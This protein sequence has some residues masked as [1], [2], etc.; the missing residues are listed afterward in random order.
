MGDKSA[1]PAPDYTAA[2]HQQG[3]DS[4]NLANAQTAANRPNVTT[5]WGSITW[6]NNGTAANPFWSGDVKLTPAQQQALNSQQNI[7]QYQS[8]LAQSLLGKEAR[9]LTGDPNK[10]P[11]AQ[12]F[13]GAGKGINMDPS[14][15]DQKTTDAVWDQFKRMQMPLQQQ[16]TE[17]IQSQLEAQG[18][19]PG[20]A[21]YDNQMNNLFNTQFNQQQTAADQALLA[22]GQMG[23]TLFNE[24]NAAQAQNYGQG[25]DQTTRNNA[26]ISQNIQNK[27]ADIA[28]GE[29]QQA[30]TTNLMNGL[31]RGNTVANPT[32]PTAGPAGTAQPTDYLGAAKAQGDASLNAYNAQTSA[33]NGL[34]AGLGTV[35]GVAAMM[36]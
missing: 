15:V 8:N 16:Q 14:L 18:L 9:Q 20:D 17:Q 24:S 2:A 29:G 31:L 22:G 35:A 10:T 36:F 30:F 6:Q 19:R 26:N 3:I 21:A 1:P 23:S 7:Q 28:L 32:F 34:M 33:S 4:I 13:T 11:E 5:P 27:Q 25:V 12:A